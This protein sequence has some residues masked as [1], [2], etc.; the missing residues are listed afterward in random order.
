M[1]LCAAQQ[2]I[3][4]VQLI[5]GWK[6]NLVLFQKLIVKSSDFNCYTRLKMPEKAKEGG[7]DL[8]M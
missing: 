6:I 1:K 5:G 3:N 2:I 4:I 7:D 8:G